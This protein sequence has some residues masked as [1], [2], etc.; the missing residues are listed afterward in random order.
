MACPHQNGALNGDASLWTRP[1]LPPQCKWVLGEDQKSPHNHYRK[2]NDRRKKFS[3]VLEAIGNTPMVR[4]SR[5]EKEYDLKCELYAKCEFFNAGGSVKDRIALR[6]IEEAERTGRIKPNE[7]YTIIEPTSG[8][9][10]IGLALCSAVKGYRCIIVLPEKMSAEKVNVL[11]AL[12][13]EIVRT[14]TSAAF[15]DPVS[16]IRVAQK[17][18]REIPKA[19]ILDQYRNPGNPVAHYDTTAAEMLEQLDDRID[20]AVMGAG[21]GGTISGIGRKLKEVCPN[22]KMIGVDPEGSDLALPVEINKTDV[23]YYEI[24]GIGYD[25]IPSVIDRSVIDKWY[26]C[27]DKTSLLMAR[28][29]IRVEGLLCGGSS[30]A[31]VSIAV[32][33]AKTMKEGERCVAVCPDSIRNYMTKH[34]MT[35]WM[36]ERDFLPIPADA[37]SLW[38]SNKQVKDIG[39]KVPMVV[40]E[41][42]LCEDVAAIMTTLHYDQLP[43]V[44]TSDKSLIGV[45]TMNDLA[46][47]LAAKKINPKSCVKVALCSNFKKAKNTT[48]LWTISKMFE[49]AKFIIVTGNDTEYNVMKSEDVV[50]YAKKNTG[51][52]SLCG[53]ISSSDFYNFLAQQ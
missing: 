44:N 37:M 47:K 14:P 18:E 30:G 8:N 46:I 9:T 32:E 1:D 2:E 24:E 21:T 36:I 53:I 41:E 31:A 16:H 13:A 5:L 38:W 48:N 49:S 20:A 11:R 17:L 27:N 51:D 28:K 10:G 52:G 25:F 4:L 42:T 22:C 26:K 29:L 23:T 40:Y 34:L 6:M 15:D 33:Y 3:S 43:V 45:V 35:D 12:G 50:T 39:V 19:V 7:G